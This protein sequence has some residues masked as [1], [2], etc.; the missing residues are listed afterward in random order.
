MI[1]TIFG[2]MLLA[3]IKHYKIDCLFSSWVFYPT[4]LL[5]CVLLFFQVNTFLGNYYFVQFASIFKTIYLYSYLIPVFALKL[6]KPALLGSGSIMIGTLLN[7]FV[8]SQNG[9]KMPVFPSLSYL[10]GYVKSDSFSVVNDIHVLGSTNT[11]WKI[12]TDYIDVGYSVL[13]IGDL[14]IHFF[15]FLILYETIVA[16]NVRQNSTK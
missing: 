12:L 13:S 5:E 4:L 11:N 3:K 7:N 14:L 16:L 2:A 9:G 1:L 6:Y 15:S 8:M 10:T